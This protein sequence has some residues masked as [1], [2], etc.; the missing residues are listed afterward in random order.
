MLT[1]PGAWGEGQLSA[2]RGIALAFVSFV[3]TVC[4]ACNRRQERGGMPAFTEIVCATAVATPALIVKEL[5]S[6]SERTTRGTGPHRIEA[7]LC[8]GLAA[9]ASRGLA[10]TRAV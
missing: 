9:A 5:S 2:T 3:A 4:A 6:A 1:V 10:S 7:A 8:S